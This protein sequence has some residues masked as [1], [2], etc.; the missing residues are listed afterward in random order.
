MSRTLLAIVYLCSFVA[1]NPHTLGTVTVDKVTFEKVI[2]KFDV[3]LAKF[4]D[5]FRTCISLATARS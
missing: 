1:S 5:K 4:D 3:V 2:K